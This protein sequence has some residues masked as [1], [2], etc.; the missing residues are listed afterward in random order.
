M[1]ADQKIN[2][3]K[4][5]GFYV[6]NMEDEYGEEFAGEFRWMN[7]STAEFQDDDTS[8]SEEAAWNDC[9]S[10]YEMMYGPL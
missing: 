3:L 2:A 7:E 9:I 4:R 1:Q 8:D 6:E 5:K 10:Y